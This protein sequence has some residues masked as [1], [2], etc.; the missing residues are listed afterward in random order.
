MAAVDDLKAL[1]L[2]KASLIT[3]DID[4]AMYLAAIDN[5]YPLAVARQ[6][7][8]G[9]SEIQSYSVGGRSVSRNQLPTLIR[10][11]QAAL[12][13]VLKYLKLAGD[14][15]MDSRWFEGNRVGIYTS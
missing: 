1:L 7:L 5:W 6:T 13:D 2:T 9:N 4:Q 10:Q 8:A 14:G 12:M 15:L 11:E 3:F